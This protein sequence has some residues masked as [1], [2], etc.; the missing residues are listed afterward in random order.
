MAAF[1]SCDSDRSTLAGWV[2]GSSLLHIHE[3]PLVLYPWRREL[4]PLPLRH[5]GS[6]DRLN[7]V[8]LCDRPTLSTDALP[9]IYPS[10]TSGNVNFIH[11]NT[12]AGAIVGTAIVINWLVIR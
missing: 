9:H 1:T 11:C 5:G 2:G 10:I 8:G 12:T 7:R 3:W 6:Y 4:P